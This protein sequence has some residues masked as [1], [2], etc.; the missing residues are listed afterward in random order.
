MVVFILLYFL[1]LKRSN[2]NSLVVGLCFVMFSF[3]LVFRF[4][5]VKLLFYDFSFV[6]SLFFIKKGKKNIFF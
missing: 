4:D 2:K 5:N 1:V 3:L 6:N